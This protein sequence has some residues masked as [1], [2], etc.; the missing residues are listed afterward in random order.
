MPVTSVAEHTGQ[1]ADTRAA[2][3]VASSSS[4]TD[5]DDTASEPFEPRRGHKVAVALVW[6]IL[7]AGYV[8][9]IRSAGIGPVESLRIATRFLTDSPL[10]PL[11]F[12]A[13]YAVRP[14]FFFSAG[15]LSVAGGILFGPILG[16]ALTIIGSN[17]GAALAYGIGR[18]FMDGA[19]LPERLHDWTSRMRQ[20]SFETVFLLRI[21]YVPYDMVNYA[22]GLLQIRFLA[23]IAATAIAAGAL[24]SQGP[25]L[26]GGRH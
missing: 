20:F 10:G 2:S 11:L 18:W 6:A 8:V 23:F 21:M 1:G 22:A 14:L 7:V 5:P 15:L 9:A 24:L 26:S 16:I 17:L 12:V 13:L 25:W 3:E 19:T 4:M